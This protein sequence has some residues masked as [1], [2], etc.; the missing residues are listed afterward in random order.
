MAKSGKRKRNK[1]R[2][3]KKYE[4]DVENDDEDFD[5]E[6][7]LRERKRSQA[8]VKHKMSQKRQDKIVLAIAAI[9]IVFT[10]SG[11]FY[12]VNFI[13]ADEGSAEEKDNNNIGNYTASIHVISDTTHKYDKTSWHILANDGFTNFLL[14]VSNS[15]TKE[16]TFKLSITKL[17]SRFKVTFNKNNFKIK[18]GNNAVVIAEVTT[19]ISYEYRLPTPIKIN[20]ISDFAKSVID[21]VEI[22]LTVKQ[23]K[24]NEEVLV[25]DKVA[26]YYS[27]IFEVNGSLF[28]YSLKN[29]ETSDPLYI[30]L[31]DDIQYDTFESRQYVTV[32]PGFKKG[33]IGMVPGE[34]HS[35]V[36]PPE[37]GYPKD[38]DLGGKTLIFEVKLLSNDRNV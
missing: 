6:P 38:Y 9:I 34:T 24:T 23:L 17:D 29:P 7:E 1:A 28:D 10:L 25:G 13:A 8:A 33:I 26:A 21:N 3:S 12:F 22:D 31:S 14:R 32:I 27:G 19:T 20:L 4:E 5:E 15:G 16:D 30:S 2:H 37:L 35:I 36:V 18:P 11:Y